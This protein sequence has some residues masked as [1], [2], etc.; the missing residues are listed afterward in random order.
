LLNR[1]ISDDLHSNPWFLR[2]EED[3]SF[4]ENLQPLRLITAKIIRQNDYY[5]PRYGD[6]I[7]SEEIIGSITI[8]KYD[9]SAFSHKGCVF[10]DDLFDDDQDC[11][12]HHFSLFDSFYEYNLNQ[13][14]INLYSED[15]KSNRINEDEMTQYI[16]MDHVFVDQK[17]VNP[18]EKISLKV[19]RMMVEKYLDR[20]CPFAVIVLGSKDKKYSHR[21]RSIE[22]L[23]KLKANMAK[24]WKKIGFKVLDN[25]LCMVISYTD[26]KS[27]PIKS[28]IG[29]K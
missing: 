4:G 8:K 10:P 3:F 12:D 17:K 18:Y 9:L 28:N 11:H 25:G 6:R 13:E 2:I 5:I 16:V 27:R 14:I 15:L 20:S 23:S 21:K 24:Y 29:E 19:I 7:N 26:L 1:K 22:N